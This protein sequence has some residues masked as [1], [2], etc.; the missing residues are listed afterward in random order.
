LII[1]RSE[2]TAISDIVYNL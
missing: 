1:G 2:A